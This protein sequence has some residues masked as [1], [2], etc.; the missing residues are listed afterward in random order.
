VLRDRTVALVGASPGGFGT[1]MA[2]AHW[3]PVLRTLG[4]RQWVGARHHHP[5]AHT[6]FGADGTLQDEAVRKS[7]AEFVAAFAAFAAAR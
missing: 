4:M 6:V 7:L 5:R 1:V 3:L 2:Q